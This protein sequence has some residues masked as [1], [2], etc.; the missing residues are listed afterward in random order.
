M[1]GS[2]SEPPLAAWRMRARWREAAFQALFALVHAAYVISSLA[3]VVYHGRAAW[4]AL[5]GPRRT[6]GPG[7][8]P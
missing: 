6:R 7:N 8:V 3:A 2:L 5:R 1:R 4:R